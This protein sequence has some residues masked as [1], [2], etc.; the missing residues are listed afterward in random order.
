MAAN[1]ASGA[2][3]KHEE[4][5]RR[6]DLRGVCRGTPRVNQTLCAWVAARA[7]GKGVERPDGEIFRAYFGKEHWSHV[8]GHIVGAA[9]ENGDYEVS[10]GGYRHHCILDVI[11]RKFE[12]RGVFY[13]WVQEQPTTREVT[14]NSGDTQQWIARRS[15]PETIARSIGAFAAAPSSASL[16][17]GSSW[18]IQPI[19][20]R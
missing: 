12:T 5:G 2:S 3:A 4:D 9:D 7:A 20:L 14:V 17:Q 18:P 19:R 1:I 13:F 6:W 10:V 8:Y 15:R 11:E 16:G